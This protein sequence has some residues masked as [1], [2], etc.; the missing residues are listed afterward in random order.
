M[1]LPSRFA[2]PDPA[3]ARR[4]I[5][6][7]GWAV[8]VTGGSAGLRATHIPCL[9]DPD[10]AADEKDLVILGHTARADPQSRD[11]T[12]GE[13]VLLVFQGPHGYISPTWYEDGPFVPTWNYEA[14]HVHGVPDVLDGEAGFAVLERTVEHFE[15]AFDEPWSLES[16]MDYARRIAPG[17]VAFRLRATRVEAKAKLSQDKPAEVRARVAAALER[18]GPHGQPELAAEMRRTL[19]T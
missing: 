7:Y 17:T 6:D 2:M 18:P 13:E 1:Y 10:T 15:A 14:V 19:N 12:A 4:L 3:E 16:S 8:L 9:L 5:D 11:L